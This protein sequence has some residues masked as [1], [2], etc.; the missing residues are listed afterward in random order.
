MLDG[1]WRMAD[2]RWRRARR[3]VAIR[4]PPSAIQQRLASARAGQ[5]RD[6]HAQRRGAPRR[7]DRCG[8]CGGGG[9]GDRGGWWEQRCD[10][11]DRAVARRASASSGARLRRF[12]GGR[13]GGGYRELPIMEDYELARRMKRIG[14]TAMLPLAV[15]TSGRRFRELGSFR[16]A[17]LNWWIIAC[18]HAGVSP[19]RLA[20]WY[21]G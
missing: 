14:R 9:R 4:H 13:G 7:D 17:A 3:V 2:G 1:G 6:S 10:R 21:R 19:E 11:G 5:R 15:R 16:T 8:V 20:R 12:D 18:Y